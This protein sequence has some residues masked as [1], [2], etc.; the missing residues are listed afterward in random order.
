M[1]ETLVLKKTNLIIA[2]LSILLIVSLAILFKFSI[3]FDSFSEFQKKNELK[4]LA[5]NLA[6]DHEGS[7]YG[8]RQFLI[9]SSY[10]AEQSIADKKTCEIILQKVSVVYPYFLN[11][12]MTDKEGNVICSGVNVPNKINISNDDD[13]KEAHETNSFA[14]SGYR[15]SKITGRPSV[16]FLQP[17]TLEGNFNGVLFV[18]FAVEWLNGFSSSFDLPSGT[19]ISKFDKDGVVFMRYPN[20][21]VWS[22]TDQSDSVFFEIIKQKKEGFQII[23]GLDG[24]KRMYY[25]RPIYH[26]GKIHAYIAVGSKIDKL[27]SSLGF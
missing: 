11:V 6:A 18:S 26:D 20:P 24:E 2:V 8:I 19:V 17:I 21:L 16:R 15:I 14:V 25:F 13:F 23:E 7:I 12:G 4:L 5:D 1:E 22:G 9:T 3:T 27:S 10:L